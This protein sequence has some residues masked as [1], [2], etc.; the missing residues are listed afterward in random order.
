MLHMRSV[1]TMHTYALVVVGLCWCLVPLVRVTTLPR[2]MPTLDHS[3]YSSDVRQEK[4]VFSTCTYSIRVRILY[5]CV[6]STCTLTT[7]ALCS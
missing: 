5:M 2:A 1:L 7:N 4:A 3:L 6:F